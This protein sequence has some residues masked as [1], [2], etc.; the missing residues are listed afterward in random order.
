MNAERGLT[1]LELVVALAIGT[2]VVLTAAAMYAQSLKIATWADNTA[3]LMDKQ[4]YGVAGLVEQLR[5]AGLGIDDDYAQAVL[6]DPAQ[7]TGLTQGGSALSTRFLTQA[8]HGQATQGMTA[9]DKL[10]IRYVAPMDMYDCEGDLVLGPRRVRLTNGELVMVDGQVVI[11]SYFVSSDDDGLALR[12][13]AARYITDSIERDGSRDRRGSMYTNAVIDEQVKSHLKNQPAIR[14]PYQ[15]KG[16]GTQNRAGTVIMSDIDGFWV[17]LLTMQAGKI[18]QISIDDYRNQP[19]KTPI[20]GIKFAIISRAK[21][22][23]SVDK[24]SK[25]VQIFAKPVR[26]PADGIARRLH[27]AD[28]M[29]VNVKQQVS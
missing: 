25:L 3:I 2:L 6:I 11:E 16:A 1:L 13:D 28:V 22:D 23:L 4:L 19:T 24:S 8:N 9:S 10:T 29:F 27:T 20:I 17:Q 15:L 26:L 12:C 7:L 5:L 18:R 14:K 21:S